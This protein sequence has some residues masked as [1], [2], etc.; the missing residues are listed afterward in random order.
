TH[1]DEGPMVCPQCQDYRFKAHQIQIVGWFIQY[2]E[3]WSL[4]R[5]KQARQTRPHSFT[6]A[7]HGCRLQG[8]VMVKQKATKENPQLVIGLAARDSLHVLQNAE[9]IVQHVDLLIQDA[10]ADISSPDPSGCWR[11]PTTN[12]IYQGRLA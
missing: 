11:F 1:H 7:K 6:A 8:C 12:K 9:R 2:Q 10:D 4:V 3:F 5:G